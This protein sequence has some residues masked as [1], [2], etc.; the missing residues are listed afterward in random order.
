MPPGVD[1]MARRGL[2]IT[3][4]R[5]RFITAEMISGADLVIGMAREHLRDAVALVPDAWPKT[6][7]LKELVRRA[8]DAGP[9]RP[10]ESFGTWLAG[11]H[12]DRDPRDLLG[13]SRDD[14]VADPMGANPGFYG[15]I[16]DEIEGL[17]GALVALAW[18]PEMQTTEGRR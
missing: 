10:D 12:R 18:A 15:E 2:D 6:F 3:A 1:V 5:S 14:D 11:I 7:T 8:G 16:A 4:H 17:I 9:R 13:R